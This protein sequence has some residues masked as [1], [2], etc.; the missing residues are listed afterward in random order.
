MLILILV[1]LL[2]IGKILFVCLIVEVLDKSYVKF[3]FGGLY[4]ELEIRGYRKIYVG[5]MLGK[6]IKGF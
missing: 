3:S 5:V 4:D 1:G 2:G 6:I